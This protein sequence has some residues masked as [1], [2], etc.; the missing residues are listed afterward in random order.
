M[1]DLKD[2]EK[3]AYASEMILQA[4]SE[5]GFDMAGISKIELPESEIQNYIDWIDKKYY[6]TM[7]YLREGLEIRMNPRLLLPEALSVIS[8]GLVYKSGD[9]TDPGPLC[10]RISEYAY[11][12]DYHRVLKK[13]LKQ[14]AEKIQGM[15]PETASRWFVDSAPVFEKLYGQNA[16]LGTKGKNS[17]LINEKTGSKFFIGELITSLPLKPTDR[18]NFDPCKSCRLCMERCPTG[19]ITENRE[20]NA[21]KCIAY[22]TIEYR[23]IIPEEYCRVMG[24][25]IFGCDECQN[26][27]PWNRRRIITGEADFAPRYRDSDLELK[28]LLTMTEEQYLKLFEG[29]VIRRTGWVC[30]MRNVIIA[31]GNSGDPSLKKLIEKFISDDN[32]ILREHARHAAEKLK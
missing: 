7:N 21:S 17:L 26:C 3:A 10:G 4:A 24:N 30:F 27:C 16:G 28:T 18:V 11:G 32:E 15:F 22:L 1:N 5:C 31:A 8:A 13:K 6:G 23:G 20:I 12:R 25:R 19:A 14:L 9:K 29:S 2:S